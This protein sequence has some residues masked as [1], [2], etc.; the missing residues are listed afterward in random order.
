MPPLNN[1]DLN[2]YHP[3]NFSRL[4]QESNL[5][6]S[7]HSHLNADALHRQL[8]NPPE[9]NPSECSSVE[10]YHVQIRQA[11]NQGNYLTAI[12]LLNRLIEN[13][14][15]RCEYY[16]NRG[17]MRHYCHQ[18]VLAI[19]D[20]DHALRLDPNA[21]RIYN[22]RANCYA[23]QGHWHQA[24]ADYD[25]CIDLNPCNI[26]ARIN[27]AITLR[28]MGQYNEALAN[29]DTALLL[30]AAKP[31]IKALIYLERGRIFHLNGD[32]NCAMSD[33]RKALHESLAHPPTLTFCH[34]QHRIQEFRDE[35]LAHCN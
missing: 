23:A 27:Q 32:W 31:F 9:S 21:D 5:E 18:W 35:L 4:H 29:L 33:Y 28:D 10:Q 14:P 7:A 8:G 12:K 20:Y 26:K 2:S 6:P 34:L 11:A 16:S 1:T 22:N 25:R 17:L 13:D 19:A 3:S 24:L 30:G 15:H